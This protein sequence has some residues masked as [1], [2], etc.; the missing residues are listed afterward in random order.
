MFHLSNTQVVYLVQLLTYHLQLTKSTIPQLTNSP[1]SQMLNS[2]IFAIYLTPT[3]HFSNEFYIP[4]NSLPGSYTFGLSFMSMYYSLRQWWHYNMILA[5]YHVY[6]FFLT[7]HPIRPKHS[8]IS[9]KT[10]S[11]LAP[12]F[13][14]YKVSN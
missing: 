9:Y 13:H 8:T 12:C 6:V 5:C 2:I 1:L 7:F 11:S 14:A 4:G 3:K 10:F